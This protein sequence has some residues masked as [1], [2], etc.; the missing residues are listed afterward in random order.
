MTNPHP[1][2]K[3]PSVLLLAICEVLAVSLWFSATAVVP[4][5]R[6]EFGLG[7]LQASLFSSGVSI[8]FVCGTL[9]SAS[10]G[11]ADRIPPKIYF[12]IATLTAAAANAAI[13]LT[14]PTSSLVIVLRILTGLCMAGIYPI[15]MKM[16]STWAKGDAGLLVGLLVGAL[17]VGSAAPHVLN[18]LDLSGHDWRTPILAS[19]ILAVISALLIP[20]AKLGHAIP[21]APP[22]R[23]ALAFHAW[24]DRPLRLANFGYFGHMWELYAMWAWIGLF[25]FESF[26]A[27]G[28][29]NARLAAST[30]T[31]ATI[32]VGGLGSLAA[33][34]AADR[35]G[36]TTV[37]IL[38]MGIS[39]SCA[40]LIGFFFGATPAAVLFIALVWGISVVADSAQ[41]S[42]CIIELSPPDILGTML[43]T[44]TCIGFLISLATIH[45][46]PEF[47][48]LLGWKFAFAPLA[49]GPLL[50]IA[51]MTRLRLLP[52]AKALAGGHR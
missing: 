25:L 24:R 42:T 31:F 26:E 29:E 33:G 3:W 5:L 14:D 51:A 39:G 21:K 46:V 28:M 20:F 43:T 1:P 35:V 18:L 48:A 45:L 36:R 17:T 27:S 16:V 41:F 37:T 50:G 40:V 22:F 10:L 38:A 30:A 34:L 47:I 23:P 32:A 52:A 2:K 4:V 44:Q 13:V 15:G 19:S 9:L 6:D 11:L 49:I 7:G 8:G 12:S